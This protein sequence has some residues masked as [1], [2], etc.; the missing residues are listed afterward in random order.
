MLSSY[1]MWEDNCS[2]P[3]T[4]MLPEASEIGVSTMAGLIVLHD[5]GAM[6]GVM[7][8]LEKETLK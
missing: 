2:I 3:P 8:D 7:V 5:G 4:S 6:G 1:T